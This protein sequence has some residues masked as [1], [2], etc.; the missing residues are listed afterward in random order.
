MRQAEINA[1][2]IRLILDPETAS[3][4]GTVEKVTHLITTESISA[5][6][7]KEWL[8]SMTMGDFA[9][10]LPES[11]EHHRQKAQK[12]KDHFT[13]MLRDDDNTEF[14]VDNLSDLEVDHNSETEMSHLTSEGG[15]GRRTLNPHAKSSP[16]PANSR[17]KTRRQLLDVL[18][19]IQC[20]NKN[21][22]WNRNSAQT[23]HKITPTILQR[24]N[25]KQ[26]P[27]QTPRIIFKNLPT[28]KIPHKRP[29]SKNSLKDA[30]QNNGSKQQNPPSE[31]L[32]NSPG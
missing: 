5:V 24:I 21:I 20:R 28:R 29:S 13:K 22:Q 7:D 32:G 19:T 9:H 6:A 26:L 18:K 15:E 16:S 25:P 14:D 2:T 30:S 10:P 17:N 31:T 1:H 23:M 27:A 11:W 3:R 12:N 4:D 8:E